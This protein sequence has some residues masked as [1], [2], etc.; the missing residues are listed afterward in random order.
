MPKRAPILLAG[1]IAA[2]TLCAGVAT[3]QTPPT[4]VLNDQLELGDVIAGQTLNVVVV[5]EQVTV[6]AAAAGN[7]VSATVENG[8]MQVQSR[9]EMRGQTRGSIDL[10]LGEIA[11]P[12]NLSSHATAN[13]GDAAAYGGDMTV[14]VVQIAGAAT[15]QADTTIDGPAGRMLE[16][17]S[18]ASTAIANN[19]ALGLSNGRAEGSIDQT[20]DASTRALTNATVQYIPAGMSFDAS[21]VS[22]NAASTGAYGSQELDIR[23]R[24]TGDHTQ[25]SAIV[26]GGNAWDIQA[27]TNA[28]ANNA[29]VHNQGGSVDVLSEQENSG[30]LRAETVLG[31]YDFG[32]ASGTA[33]GAANALEVGNNDVLV[34]IDSTQLN[35]G[36][37]EVVAGFA[38][39]GGYDVALGATAIGNT[40]TGYACSECIGYLDA[41]NTQVNT[42]N[43]SATATS[44]VGAGNRSVIGSATAVGNS[45]TFYVT[46]NGG[47]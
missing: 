10:T 5:D 29:T 28:M 30:Y 41:T 36:G 44:T 26:S 33:Y 23:Q 18:A 17:G 19:Q 3:S 15:V 40:V 38:G 37:V 2:T 20:S 35:S 43:V 34:V 47:G 45:A 21:A 46:G 24:M 11:G 31:A 42:G 4:V 14:E 25:A 13:A 16:G 7:A 9:Q 8:A 1:T 22:N 6:S 32:A 27:S 12:A 39:N